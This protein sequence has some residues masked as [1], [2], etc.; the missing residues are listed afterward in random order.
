MHPQDSFESGAKNQNGVGSNAVAATIHKLV[1]K[2][3][4]VL[5]HASDLQRYTHS[6]QSGDTEVQMW[7]GAILEGLVVAPCA[8]L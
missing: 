8:I 6:E 1:K 2:T 7:K 4:L 5:I 3:V